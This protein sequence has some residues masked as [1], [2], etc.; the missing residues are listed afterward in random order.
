MCVR[1]CMRACVC[2]CAWAC[3]HTRVQGVYMYISQK[4]I[5]DVPFNLRDVR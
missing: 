1:V 4:H 2:V 3:A 5:L